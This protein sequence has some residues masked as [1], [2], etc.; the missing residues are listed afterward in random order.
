M[1]AVGDFP[2]GL[3]RGTTDVASRFHHQ[4]VIPPVLSFRSW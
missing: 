2:A 3:I 1:L 4:K